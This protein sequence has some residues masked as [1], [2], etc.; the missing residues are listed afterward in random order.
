MINPGEIHLAQT[1][2]GVRP[3]VLVSREEMNRGNWVVAVLITSAKF[4]LRRTLRHC[5]AFSAGEFGL[6]KDWVT[7]AEAISSS[8]IL[9]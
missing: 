7:L 4:S 5:V 3:V 2:A 1:D 9:S 6:D 8:E